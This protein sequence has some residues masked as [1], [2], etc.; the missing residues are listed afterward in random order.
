M[1]IASILFFAGCSP[2]PMNGV[3]ERRSA[4]LYAED[5]RFKVS[6][7]SG[8]REQPYEADGKVGE[9]VPY[10]LVTVAP[11]SSEKFDVDAAYTYEACVKY[12]GGEKKFGGALVVHPFAASFSAEFPFETTGCEVTVRV[13]AGGEKY[14]YTMTSLAEKD[15]I[16]YDTA[17]EAAKKELGDA[18]VGEIRVK[19]IKSPI[20]DGVCWHVEFCGDG[21]R[22]G[23][24]L[25]PVTAKVLAKK[26]A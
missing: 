14:D 8:V 1:T 25:D 26:S 17:I 19:L 22:S 7:V 2:D 3:S 20:G 10:T 4:Y 11:T 9:L 16:G 5:D 6:A 23:V 21:G 24:L 15:M 12:D 18:A 13:F